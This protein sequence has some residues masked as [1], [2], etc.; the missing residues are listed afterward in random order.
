[1]VFKVI[2][3]TQ[4]RDWWTDRGTDN[5]SKNNVS[6][7]VRGRHNKREALVIFI[8]SK[9]ALLAMFKVDMIDDVGAFFFSQSNANF[10]ISKLALLAMFKVDMIDDVGAFFSPKVTQISLS[11]VV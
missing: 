10:I 7:H 2:E 9:L 3:Q 8:I 11:L 1:M 6:T 4:L 5:R